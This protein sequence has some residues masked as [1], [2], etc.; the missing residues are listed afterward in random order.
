M[1]PQPEQQARDAI[2]RLLQQAGRQ[3]CNAADANITGYPRVAVREFRFLG[4]RVIILSYPNSE[5]GGLVRV[6]SDPCSVG[7]ELP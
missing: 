2:D 5:K 1:T 6:V 7:V 4:S 3:V